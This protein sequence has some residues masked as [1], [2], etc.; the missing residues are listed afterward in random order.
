MIYPH[1]ASHP[2]RLVQNIFPSSI[3]A[4]DLSNNILSV[5]RQLFDHLNT[6]RSPGRFS[7]RTRAKSDEKGVNEEVID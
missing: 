3:N 5:T 2:M 7:N 1:A 4:S 6:A